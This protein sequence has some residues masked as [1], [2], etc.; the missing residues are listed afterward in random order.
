LLRWKKISH[1]Y[2]A[3]MISTATFLNSYTHRHDVTN[4]HDLHSSKECIRRYLEEYA[5]HAF[6]MNEGR[7]F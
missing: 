3:I 5:G 2:S 7:I 1:D 4:L 6:T